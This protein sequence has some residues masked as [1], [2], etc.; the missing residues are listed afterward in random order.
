M[1]ALVRG[2]RW[3]HNALRRRSDVMEAWT[4]LVA[5][6]LLWVGAPMAGLAAGWWAHDG[7]R[8]TAVAQHAER[9]R[10]R[11]EVTQH[12]PVA[13]PTAEG[14]RQPTYRVTVRW[15]E[16]GGKARTDTARVPAGTQVGEH[17][18]IWLND[19]GR[20]VPAPVDESAVWQH[21]LTAA[22]CATGVFAV[23][24]LATHAV[25]RMVATRRRLAEWE[26]E[27]AR[28]G[29]DWRRHRT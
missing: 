2:W 12:A 22:I 29:P 1:R 14:E 24:V 9:H 16:P 21:T 28:T 26:R 17:T 10:V 5:A 19:R 3:R 25:V 4:V 7:A 8:A 15:T 20:V 27:W 11:A 23:G 18:D 13:P 6:V